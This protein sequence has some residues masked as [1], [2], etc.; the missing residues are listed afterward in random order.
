MHYIIGTA[1]HIDHGKSSLIKALNG[2]WGDK[3]IEEKRRGITIDLSFSSLKD[4]ENC[5]SFIDVP[6][7]E[8]LIS[9]MISGAYGFDYCMV[10]V[11]ANEGI[12]PQTKE[13]LAILNFLHVKE[14]IVVLTKC[15][16]ATD[17]LINSQ[18]EAIKKEFLEYKNLHINSLQTVSIK[19]INSI[20]SLKESLFSL[21]QKL[22]QN[23]PQKDTTFRYYIDR[24]FSKSGL[25]TIVTGTILSGDISVGEKV[26]ISQLDKASQVKN[27][28]VH[29]TASTTAIIKQ[30]V[31]LN[32]GNIKQNELKKGMLLT[33]KGY[34]RGF[35][36]IDIFLTCKPKISLPHNAKVTFHLGTQKVNGTLLHVNSIDTFTKGFSTFKSDEPIFSI[37]GDRCI[38]SYKGEVAG[39]AKIINPIY[40]PIKKR[41]KLPILEALK[42][43]DFEKAFLLLSNFHKKGFGLISTYQRFGLSHNEAL[44]ILEKNEDIFLDKNALIAYPK[45]ILDEIQELILNIYKKNT[46]ALISPKS[47]NLKHRWISQNL[48][49]KAL[50]DLENSKKLL[51]VKGV[52][53]KSGINPKEL[54]DTIQNKILSI[55][56]E[57]DIAPLAPYDIYDS[58]DIDRFL[59]DNALKSLTKSKKV[60][61]LQHNF[62]ILSDVL[63]KVMQLCRDIIE[64]DGF[65]DIKNLKLRLNLSRK[66][67]IAYLEYL[68][69]FEDISK[70]GVK[71]VLSSK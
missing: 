33:K 66:Y 25:G 1:G 14:C 46:Y 35:K 7:H 61:R 51:H 38:I 8:K 41:K 63:S 5:I 49:L 10:V 20:H 32:L 27:I 40:E 19:D 55:L 18:K 68:D 6:G 12:M 15:D 9:T 45:T 52:W 11:D 13:H 24:V 43:K 58:L 60:V 56:K 42:D 47:L 16:L 31:A 22:E 65:V 4:G 64:K 26:W 37:Y 59:G 70:D 50:K 54:E 23:K 53:A 57:G 34:I 69:N 62:F 28:E 39:G 36:N 71:R 29:N 2:F 17:E 21:T 44:E 30:R 3:S 67:L 48:A